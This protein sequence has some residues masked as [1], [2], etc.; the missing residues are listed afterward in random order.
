MRAITFSAL[1]VSSLAQAVFAAPYTAAQLEEKSKTTDLNRCVNAITV[2]ECT[3]SNQFALQFQSIDK[4]AYDWA[5]ANGWFVTIA[6]PG[7]FGA[8]CK[9]GCFDPDTRILT[10]RNQKFD[11]EKASSI[12]KGSKL[13]SLKSDASLSSLEFEAGEVVTTTRGLESQPLYV[14]LLQNGSKLSVTSEHGMVLSD[15]RVVPAKDVKV[16]DSFVQAST[17]EA[18]PVVEVSRKQ[19]KKKVVNFEIGGS[20]IQNHV[21]VAEDFLIGDLAWQN[22]LKRY[23]NAISLRK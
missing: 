10:F 13:A 2:A 5:E 3:A 11:Y 9:C 12:A 19:T 22:Q 21:I 17:G 15:G 16:S 20:E 6:G 14:F 4:G 23:T 18:V 1:A 8:I 7:Q